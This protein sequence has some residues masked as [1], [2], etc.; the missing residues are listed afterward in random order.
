MSTLS[1]LRS[2]IYNEFTDAMDYIWKSPRLIESETK[3]ELEKLDVYFPNDPDLA[4]LRWRFESKRLEHAFPFLNS[5][6]NLFGIMS[7]FEAYLLRIAKLL[8]DSS[9]VPIASTKGNGT[10]RLLKY[11]RSRGLSID[12]IGL[13]P[14]VI[15]GVKIRN[16]LFHA[17]GMLEW[18]KDSTEIRRIQSSGTYLSLDHRNRKTKSQREDEVRI[19]SHALGE[20]LQINNTYVWVLTYYLREFLTETCALAD[21]QEGEGGT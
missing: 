2:R 14:Q 7:L 16:C 19:I 5:I 15:A 17:T 4:A 12:S 3:E 6:G 13:Y 9:G 20:R 21:D 18:S 1:Q 8:E 11:L 10:D